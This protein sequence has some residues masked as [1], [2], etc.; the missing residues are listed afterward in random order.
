MDVRHRQIQHGAVMSLYHDVDVVM[1]FGDV[2]AECAWVRHTAGVVHL[3]WRKIV[4]FH[5]LERAAFLHS[6][7][8]NHVNGLGLWGTQHNTSCDISGHLIGLMRLINADDCIFADLPIDCVEAVL[9]NLDAHL[10]M[11]DV[12]I[13]RSDDLNLISVQGVLSTTI[14]ERVIGA[15]CCPQPETAM[16]AGFQGERLIL[17]AESHTGEPGIDILAPMSIVGLLW[18]DLTAVARDLGG[19]PVGLDA[20]NRLR[21]EAGIPWWKDDIDESILMLEAGLDDAI[22]Y[23][24]GCYLG[25]ETLAR[26]HFRGHTNRRLA[27]LDL[28]DGPLPDRR[29]CLISDGRDAGWIASAVSSPTLNRNISLGFVRSQYLNAGTVLTLADSGLPA[30][31]STLPFVT[32]HSIPGV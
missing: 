5:G 17:A 20:L 12:Q 1:D 24:K 16:P 2:L 27:G 19:G 14:V 8:T 11:E 4:E 21:V 22:H 28:G 18:E 31:V 6:M 23:G 9:E 10:I 32:R 3:S 7:T 13:R 26:I 15:G 29:T 25:Q 30:R